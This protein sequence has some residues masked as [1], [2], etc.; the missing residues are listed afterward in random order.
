MKVKSFSRVWLFA[1]PWTAGHQAP[2]SMGFSRQEYWSGVPLPSPMMI[3]IMP[4]IY[5]YYIYCFVYI[6]QAL[7]KYFMWINSFN[8]CI[9]PMRSFISFTKK[10]FMDLHGDSYYIDDNSRVQRILSTLF[11][12]KDQ[13]P[14]FIPRT[15]PVYSIFHPSWLYCI[16]HRKL[17]WVLLD[18]AS[19]N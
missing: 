16:S 14:R 11:K 15:L 2:P 7:L 19:S 10:N 5:Y 17:I 9:N 1:T 12:A 3:I 13:E 8:S 4:N 6:C 18:V